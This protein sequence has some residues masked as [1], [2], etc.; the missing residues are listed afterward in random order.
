VGP[1]WSKRQN[2]L[3]FR[4]VAP[5]EQQQTPGQEWRGA[6]VY[7]EPHCDFEPESVKRVGQVGLESGGM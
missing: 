4:E 5:P 6:S 2:G 3:V 1:P 7:F